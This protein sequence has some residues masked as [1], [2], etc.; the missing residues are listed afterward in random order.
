MLKSIYI[1]LYVAS[2]SFIIGTS[3]SLDTCLALCFSP[4]KYVTKKNTLHVYLPI[5]VLSH[6]QYGHAARAW[7]YEEAVRFESACRNSFGQLCHV[8]WFIS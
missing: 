7:V 2:L 3:P 5:M 8:V 1:L 6:V 4:R